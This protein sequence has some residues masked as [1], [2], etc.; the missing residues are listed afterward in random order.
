MEY[1]I[2]RPD[3]ETRWIFGRGRVIRDAAGEPVRYSGIDI[4]ITERKQDEE[5]RVLLV[6]ELNHRVKNIL[7]TVQAIASQTFRGSAVGQDARDAFEGR[8]LALSKAHTLLTS[9]NWRGAGLRQLVDET[10]Q[11]FGIGGRDAQRISAQ[12]SEIELPSRIALALSMALHELATN[13]AKYGALSSDT[14]RVAIAWRIEE[15][16]A[17]RRL[18]LLW[19]ETGGPP[20]PQVRRQGF[21]SRLIEQGLARELSGEVRLDYR[22]EGVVCEITMPVSDD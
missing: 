12:G 2:V 6:N 17:G 22:S 18:R 8:I 9:E 13:A 1:R 11:P 16:P 20:V 21:G 5:H 3:G 14:G 19:Q 10:L 15:S 4:D 7:A